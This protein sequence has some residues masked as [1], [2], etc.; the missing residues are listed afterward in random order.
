MRSVKRTRPTAL[1]NAP[2]IPIFND[3]E[4]PLVWLRRRKDKNGSALI[5]SA[6]FEAGERLRADLWRAQM[7]PRVT[8]DWSGTAPVQR[9]RRSAPG[10]GIDI[11]DRVVAARQRVHRALRAV[12]SEYAGLLIDVCG[13]LKELEQLERSQG[14]PQRSAKF[15]LRYALTRLARHYGLTRLEDEDVLIGRRL[16]HWGAEDYRPNLESWR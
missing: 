9:Q 13:H 11:A 7:T 10:A 4:S 5:T 8:S 16:R 14:W 1:R 3:A 12:G 15:I 2:G 6:Q